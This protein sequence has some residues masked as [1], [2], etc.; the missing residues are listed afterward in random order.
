MDK[1]MLSKRVG[2]PLYS[3]NKFE[4]DTQFHEFE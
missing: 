2:L 1:I 3:G 4:L